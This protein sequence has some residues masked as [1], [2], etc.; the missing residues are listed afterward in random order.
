MTKFPFWGKMIDFINFY[1]FAVLQIS[2]LISYVE[3]G[4]ETKQRAHFLLI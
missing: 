3:G 2:P 4:M 1:H